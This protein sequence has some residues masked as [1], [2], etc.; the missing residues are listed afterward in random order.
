MTGLI[1]VAVDIRDDDVNG[2]VEVI[3]QSVST[4]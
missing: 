1:V 4:G 3:V 2:T